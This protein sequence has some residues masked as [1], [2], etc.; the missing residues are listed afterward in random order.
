MQFL[1]SLFSSKI[2]SKKSPEVLLP[3]RTKC[4]SNTHREPQAVLAQV[5]VWPPWN[6]FTVPFP[7]RSAGSRDFCL[8]AFYLIIAC[9]RR[10][11]P[12]RWQRTSGPE[13]V[14]G[15]GSSSPIYR[16]SDWQKSKTEVTDKMV[17]NCTETSVW[18]W[19]FPWVCQE[20]LFASHSSHKS[21]ELYTHSEFT[22]CP[23]Q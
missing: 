23:A 21:T 14:D 20:K 22:L 10:G 11:F 8:I 6:V 13:L 12:T 3:T 7:A 2:S 18:P 4:K 17:K 5:Q 19:E 1:I 15:K 9:L 16:Q